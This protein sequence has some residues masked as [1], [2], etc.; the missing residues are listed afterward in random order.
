ML[1]IKNLSL[2]VCNQILEASKFDGSYCNAKCE[3]SII[4]SGRI[5][6]I[7]AVQLMSMS[8]VSMLVMLLSKVV[9]TR[10]GLVRQYCLCSLC[11]CRK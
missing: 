6:Q 11:Y 8:I 7:N 5:N 3:S 2:A 10:S 9:K 4:D 1:E